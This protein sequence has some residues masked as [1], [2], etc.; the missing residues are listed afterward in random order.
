P[1]I[2][3][4]VVVD[5]VTKDSE[6]LMQFLGAT[7]NGREHFRKTNES[8]RVEHLAM[9][10]NGVSDF[11]SDKGTMF[12]KGDDD[13]YILLDL[14]L[15]NAETL[16]ALGDRMVKAGVKV[17]IPAEQQYWVAIYGQYEDPFGQVWSI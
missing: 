11:L 5:V 2:R 14:V 9:D 13:S 8:G 1:P 16:E 6:R 12:D 15:P 7:V 4:S 3:K 10:I 17:V